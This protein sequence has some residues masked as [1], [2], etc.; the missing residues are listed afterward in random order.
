VATDALDRDAGCFEA[1]T[2]PNCQRGGTFYWDETNTT[3]PNFHEHLAWVKTI[4]TGLEKPMMWWQ[5]P[6]GVPNNT[7]GGSARHYRDNRVHYLFGHIQEFIAA[8]FAGAAFGVGAGNQTDI[9]TDGGQ[10]RNAVNGY[11]AHP[12]PL[13]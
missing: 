7:P 10:F 6:F 13:P 4:T 2:D 1:K 3:S 12:V 9:F 8:G 5:V 11:F